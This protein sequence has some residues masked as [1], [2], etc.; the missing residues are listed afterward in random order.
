MK[1][2]PPLPPEDPIRPHVFD[3]IQEYD[4]RLPNWWLYTLYITIVFWVGYWSYYEWFRA[5]PTG[6]QVVDA[7][8]AKIE[9]ARL[10]STQMD[11]AS[12]WQMSQNAAF[13]DAGKAIYLANCFACHL[14]SLRGKSESPAAIGPDLTDTAWIHGGRPTEVYELITKGVL[15]KG[16]PAWGPVLGAKKIA[17][18]S[19]YIMSLHR[20]GEP[21]VVEQPKVVPQ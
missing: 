1:P 17:E 19:A 8:M 16:M 21:V 11:D 9:T 3:G 20:E 4:K 2:K 14:A 12:L 13:V 5:G 10:A 18:V 7:A 15:A 6:T